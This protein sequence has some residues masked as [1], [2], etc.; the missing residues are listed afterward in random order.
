MGDAIVS[1]LVYFYWD[2]HK[3]Q[4]IKWRLG[5]DTTAQRARSNGASGECRNKHCLQSFKCDSVISSTD[6]SKSMFSK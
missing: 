6:Q 1:I 5:V 2:L 4:L 3:E